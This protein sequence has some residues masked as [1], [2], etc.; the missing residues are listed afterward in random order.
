ME[1]TYIQLF[2]LPPD[3]SILRNA[4]PPTIDL[5]MSIEQ[6]GVL[7]PVLL[8]RPLLKDDYCEIVAGN[9]RVMAAREAGLKQIPAYIADSD[10]MNDIKKQLATLSENNTRSDNLL[11]DVQALR[12]LLA[13]GFTF[14]AIV[15]AGLPQKR[16]LS[17]MRYV[18]LP[19]EI[20]KAWEEKR[21][22]KSFA[23]E[24]LKLETDQKTAV[25][26]RVASG[27]RITAKALKE[28]RTISTSEAISAL[29]LDVGWA[30]SV[31]TAEMALQTLVSIAEKQGV[32]ISTEVTAII[33]K[34]N[35]KTQL[36]VL[37]PDEII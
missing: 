10:E 33:D 19:P 5:V 24:F 17:A 22:R 31:T 21:I 25:T 34:L 2:E 23:N 26:R 30:G 18:D 7:T 3:N 9:R 11:S 1:L 20:L 15:G 28:L 35:N 16:M 13:N 12:I 29:P 8:R 14:D 4:P 32:D 27:E 6:L 36:E 37:T